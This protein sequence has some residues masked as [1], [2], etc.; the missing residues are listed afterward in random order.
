MTTRQSGI[1][2]RQARAPGQQVLAWTGKTVTRLRRF[3]RQHTVA[4]AAAVVLGLVVFMAVAAPLLAPEDPLF[5]D[6]SK[7]ATPRI[8][9]V[10][11]GPTR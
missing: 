5:A 1:Q 3:A 6:F 10:C 2:D 7:I 9:R 11:W 8:V 4:A